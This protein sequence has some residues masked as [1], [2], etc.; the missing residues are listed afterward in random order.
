MPEQPL[1]HVVTATFQLLADAPVAWTAIDLD[2]LSST[3]LKALGRLLAFGLAERRTRI[4]C[5]AF[6]SKGDL[7][8]TVTACGIVTEFPKDV[9]ALRNAY[10]SLWLEE[11]RSW[12]A[13]HPDVPF[14]LQFNHSGDQW[15]ISTQGQQAQEHLRTNPDGLYTVLFGHDL[16]CCDDPGVKN[17]FPNGI[18]GTMQVSEVKATRDNATAPPPSNEVRVANWDDGAG[19]FAA[20]LKNLGADLGIPKSGQAETINRDSSQRLLSVFTNGLSDDRIQKAAQVLT[21][22]R[23]TANEKLTKIDALIPL[24]ATA[25][26]QQLGD[27]LGVKKQAV[28]K[29]DWWIQNRKGE[30][31]EEIGR[32]RTGHKQR[33][34]QYDPTSFRDDND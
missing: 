11:E 15:R 26:A 20:L 6:Q 31:A 33:A 9:Q 22:E 34:D 7:A 3:D 18:M 17:P 29:T 14:T 19:A 28:L 8:F 25:S 30:N 2:A 13:A 10:D 27:M 23:L 1:P 16:F 24:P 32:R 5:T 4:H 21:D 12:N